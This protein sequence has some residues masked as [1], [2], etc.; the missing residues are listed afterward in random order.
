[1]TINIC[2]KSASKQPVSMQ[3]QSIDNNTN[4]IMSPEELL[5]KATAAIRPEPKLRGRKRKFK[6]HA[7]TIRVLRRRRFNFAQIRRFLNENGVPCSYA[8]LVN[9]CKLN[10]KKK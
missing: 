2:T 3:D 6:A 4:I 7:E 1:M 9:F 10:F 5:V 8:G